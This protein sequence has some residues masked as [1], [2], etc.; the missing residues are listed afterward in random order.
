MHAWDDL[1]VADELR[2]QLRELVGRYRHRDKV[3]RDWGL[4]RRFGR[5]IGLSVLFDGPPGTGK[6]MAAGIVAGELGLDLYQIDLSR[7]VSKFVG[8][9]E[10]NLSRVFDEA[11]QARAV[12]L[13]DEADSLFSSRTRVES[14]ND[15]YAN[16]EV[17]YLLQRIERFSGV[18]ILTTNFPASLD[19][20][21]TRRLS[22]RISFGKPD[23]R[24]RAELWRTML[25]GA[26]VPRAH[27]D[28]DR[29][30]AEFELSGGHIRN[31]VLRAAFIAA[32]RD[33]SVD[34]ELL[35]IAARIE[36]KQQGMLVQGSP[37]GELWGKTD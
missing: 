17:N 33:R 18:A 26:A 37:H 34:H 5:D 8:E 10:K 11:E 4:G 16:L 30:A 14:A 36:L 29:L 15:R 20:A 1:V 35:R 25:A 31:A 24:A 3:L 9:T 21:F 28:F 27:I 13:F 19:D 7:V 12:L 23:A 6:T 2:L 32:T 22:M